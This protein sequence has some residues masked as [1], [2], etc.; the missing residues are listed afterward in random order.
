[1]LFYNA[2]DAVADPSEADMERSA[3]NNASAIFEDYHAEKI[4]LPT[5]E[6][7][8]PGKTI[9]T[10]GPEWR[11]GYDAA[12]KAL[13]NKERGEQEKMEIAAYLQTNAAW[14]KEWEA[15]VTTAESMPKS[16]MIRKDVLMANEIYQKVWRMTPGERAKL[17]K[18]GGH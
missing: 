17:S 13:M 5:L 10:N 16:V 9:T 18:N 14:R 2:A 6:D 8:P 4:P 11:K 7:I 3:V 1:M 12:S 15:R